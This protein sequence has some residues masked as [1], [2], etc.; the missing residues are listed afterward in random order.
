MTDTL[1]NSTRSQAGI[2]RLLIRAD[3]SV[4]MGSGHVMRCLAIAQAWQ[5]A[6]GEV[7]FVCAEVIATLADRLAGEGCEL[8]SIEAPAGSLSDANSVI[9]IATITS[10]TALVFDGYRFGQEYDQ[11]IALL[12]V[13]TLA[14]DD[15]G[16]VPHYLASFVLNQNLAASPS[17]YEHCSARTELLLGTKYALLRREFLRQNNWKTREYGNTQVL[18]TLGGSDADNITEKVLRAIIPTANSRNLKIRVVLGGLNPHV[19]AIAKFAKNHTFVDVHVNVSDMSEHYHW[20]DLAITA[21]GRSN[22]EMCYFGLPRILIVTAD[23]QRGIAEQLADYE[24]AQNLG[25]A[26]DFIANEL[27]QTVCNQLS[28]HTWMDHARKIAA[29]LVDGQ[30]ARRV[31]TKLINKPFNAFDRSFDDKLVI[32]KEKLDRLVLRNATLDDAEILWIW[33]NDVVTRKASRNSDSVP[34]HDH[35]RWLNKY[36]A[37]PEQV[38]LVA[39]IKGVPVGTVR[40]DNGDVS[41]TVAPR[42]RGCG[43]GRKMVTEVVRTANVPLKAVAH[44]SNIGSQAIAMA[45]GFRQ[46]SQEGEWLTFFRPVNCESA[47]Q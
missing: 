8:I 6:G 27:V 12:R 41:W 20:A 32:T 4:S 15:Y 30:G 19:K 16:N 42:A 10:A 37:R 5:D 23:N 31:V 7:T 47:T 29:S 45:A 28:D 18:V 21:G 44:S 13:P 14:I 43:V 9:E 2:G 33:R 34:W 24:I 39:E 11:R 3:A 36:L 40:I 26:K 22:W 17:L 38:L 35:I 46:H 1:N 25:S